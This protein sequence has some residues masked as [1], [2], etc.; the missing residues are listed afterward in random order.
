MKTKPAF[1]IVN[2]KRPLV[3]AILPED[4]KRG[5]KMDPATCAIACAA[6]RVFHTAEVR[7]HLSRIYV[8]QGK[9]WVRYMTPAS[10]RSELIA[11]D[12]GGTF[13]VGEHWLSPPSP[14]RQTG[15]HQGGPDRKLPVRGPRHT[16]E[17]VRRTAPWGNNQEAR[18]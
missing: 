4:I 8:L 3:L 10:L 16:T 1:K 18:L 11:F 6:R 9:H 17:N 13:A 12:R 5:K 15:A 14:A 2:A 7:V